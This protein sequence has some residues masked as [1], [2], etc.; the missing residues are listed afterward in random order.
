[1]ATEILTEVPLLFLGSPTHPQKIFCCQCGTKSIPSPESATALTRYTCPPCCDSLLKSRDR[2]TAD[3]LSAISAQIDAA[4]V[5]E[6]GFPLIAGA[7]S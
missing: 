5:Q 3:M 6:S 1:M 4:C 7:R 2:G